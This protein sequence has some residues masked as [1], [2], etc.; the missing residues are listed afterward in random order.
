MFPALLITLRETLEAAIVV[1]IVLA[2]LAKT[3]QLYFRKYVWSG[4]G[5]GI[6]VA[7]L[8]A[9]LLEFFF[10]GFEGTTEALFEGVLM[11]VTAAFITWMILWV[12]RQKGVAQRIKERVAEHISKSYG[13]GISILVAV[14][15]WREGTETVLY[16]KSSSIIGQS[17]QLIGAV[18]GIAAAIM[19]AYIL[20]RFALRADLSVVFNVTSVFLIMFAAGLVAHGVHEFQELGVLP[21]FAFD[22]VFNISHILSHEST[23]GAFLRTLFGYTSTPTLLE[24]VAY[25]SAVAFILRLKRFTDRLLLKPAH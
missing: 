16:L 9:A 2:F 21:V 12:H 18:L 22:P 14:A 8:L 7:L 25:A 3:D 4:V 11:L 10:A 1:G 20:F 6:F 5:A 23:F 13:L 19:F 17:G 24:V 15:V